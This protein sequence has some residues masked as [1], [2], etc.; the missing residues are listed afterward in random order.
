MPTTACLPSPNWVRLNPATFLCSRFWASVESFSTTFAC[1]IHL[2]PKRGVW[3][4]GNWKGRWSVCQT[5]VRANRWVW[6]QT[7][8]SRQLL[9]TLPKA[10]FTSYILGEEAQIKQ[11]NRHL[12]IVSQVDHISSVLM[13]KCQCA[14]L[15]LSTQ[16]LGAP[17]CA[18]L[19]RPDLWGRFTDRLWFP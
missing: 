4:V 3:R 14:D 6:H 19:R 15:G 8:T 7:I 13:P 5:K 1:M 2:L 17:D 12:C 16:Q 18:F 9:E 10:R 11:A